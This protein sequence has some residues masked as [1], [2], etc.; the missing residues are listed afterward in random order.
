MSPLSNSGNLTAALGIL[1]AFKIRITLVTSITSRY[2]IKRE[3][4]DDYK[5]HIRPG[6]IAGISLVAIVFVFLILVVWGRQRA[7][8]REQATMHRYSDYVNNVVALED[9]QRHVRNGG[10][11]YGRGYF[12]G[13][14]YSED[15][16]EGS[17]RTRRLIKPLPP[18]PGKDGG[19]Q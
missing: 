7:R 3:I 13:P 10:Y 15:E 18:T 6:P 12:P 2:H 16:D 4:G 8:T 11:A 9:Q 19:S 5:T 1:D 17:R 14:Q